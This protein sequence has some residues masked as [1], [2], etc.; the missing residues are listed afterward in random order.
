MLRRPLALWL[1]SLGLVLSPVYYYVERVIL[2]GLP[3]TDPVAIV[4]AM[5]ALKI[6]AAVLGVPVGLLLVRVHPLSWYAIFA[7]GVYTM[8]ANLAMYLQGLVKLSFS[9]AFAATG[10][11]VVLYFTRREVLSPFFNPRLRGWESDRIRF[12]ARSKLVLPSGESV[13][14]HTWDISPSGLYVETDKF[15]SPGTTLDVELYLDREAAMT[16]KAEV[17]W[18]SAGDGERP[19]GVGLRFVQ[20]IRDTMEQRLKAATQRVYAR[21]PFKLRVDVAGKE[22]LSCETFDLS[23]TGCYLVTDQKF[24]AGEVLKMTLHLDGPLEI[25]GTVVRVAN[26][27][28]GIGVRFSQTPMRL[29]SA[30]KDFHARRAEAGR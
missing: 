26:D 22:T 29:Q 18:S 3:F 11:L 15:L 21:V 7:Y 5:P 2:S 4:S 6:G 16:E 14:S 13:E 10:F 23:R 27:P 30:L 9:M 25:E 28:K 17:I 8:A 19:A 24:E 1:I 12:R 20:D